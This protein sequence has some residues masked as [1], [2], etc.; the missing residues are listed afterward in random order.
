[1]K[2]IV[3]LLKKGRNVLISFDDDS[4]I[5]VRENIVYDHGFRK[6]DELSEADLDLLARENELLKI[7]EKSFDLLSRRSHSK[8]ELRLKLLKK[9]FDYHLISAVLNDLEKIKYLDDYDFAIKF[10]DEKIKRR[11]QGLNLIRKQLQKKGISREYIDSVLSRY[12][13]DEIIFNNALEIGKKKYNFL[14]KKD[15]DQNKLNLKLR[16]FLTG[17]GYDYEIIN[18]VLNSIITE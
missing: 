18:R 4:Q 17:R 2:R 9:N 7:K 11:K 1:M 16:A 8:S 13:D 5:L 12:E 14:L 10:T 15:I 3:R 6:N